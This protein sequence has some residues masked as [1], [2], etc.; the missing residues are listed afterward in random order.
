MSWSLG[1][2]PHWNRDI[3]Y[4]V[5]AF[6]DHPGCNKKIDRG[7]SFV[8]GGEPFGG[9][10]GCGLYFCGE[11][12]Q[13]RHPRGEDGVYQNCRRCMTYRAPFHPKPDHPEWT[14]WK[15]TDESWADWRDSNSAIVAALAQ[16]VPA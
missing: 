11:H 7:L 1:F 9:E 6:C 12:L 15:L 3:G 10:F 13:L 2:D 8:C 14:K 5:P 4:G 16:S